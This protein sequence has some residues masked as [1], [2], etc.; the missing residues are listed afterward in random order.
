MSVFFL[1]VKDS[2]FFYPPFLIVNSCYIEM[3]LSLY[4]V[5]WAEC[6]PVWF[7]VQLPPSHR[8]PPSLF[9]WNQEQFLGTLLLVIIWS[10]ILSYQ[11]LLSSSSPRRHALPSQ[12]CQR[13]VRQWVALLVKN[14]PAN[15]REARNVSSIPGLG[16]SPAGGRGNPRQHSC[17]WNPGQMGLVDYSP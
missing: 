3:G 1:I 10:L 15:A 8:A 11:P 17:L 6:G 4:F 2:I 14:P 12:D 7:H 13:W 16:R 5:Y 9:S